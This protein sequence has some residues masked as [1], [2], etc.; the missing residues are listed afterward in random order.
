MA[1]CIGWHGAESDTRP[2]IFEL[3]EKLIVEAL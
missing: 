3:Q 2:Y 1:S